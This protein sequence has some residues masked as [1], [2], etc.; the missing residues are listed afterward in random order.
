[1]DATYRFAL[2]YLLEILVGVEMQ[3]EGSSCS[4]TNPIDREKAE[5]VIHDDASY[6]NFDF[7]HDFDLVP[8]LFER[9]QVQLLTLVHDERHDLV[10]PDLV[11]LVFKS[12]E[13][14]G[15]L[16]GQRVDNVFNHR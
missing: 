7:L 1:M 15:R 9:D 16:L 13:L 2:L 5:R 3:V 14:K 6:L 4:D 11:A 8:P 12:D 10:V